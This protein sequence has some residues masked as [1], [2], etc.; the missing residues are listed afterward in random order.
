MLSWQNTYSLKFQATW[1]QFKISNYWLIA[2]YK[3]MIFICL[4]K[5]IVLVRENFYIQVSVLQLQKVL[6]CPNSTCD[7]AT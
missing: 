5:N 2:P 7:I 6:S 3:N 4:N 1:K